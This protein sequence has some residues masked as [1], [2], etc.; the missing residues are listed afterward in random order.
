M[1]Q[2]V[3][4][5]LAA[6]MLG[7]GLMAVTTRNLI[8]SVLWLAIALVSTAGVYALLDASFLASDHR[9]R[10]LLSELTETLAYQVGSFEAGAEYAL[11]AILQSPNF[12][13][14][15]ELGEGDGKADGKWR[16]LPVT[17]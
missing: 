17:R 5:I 4:A 6:L 8:H 3:F 10:P 7:A 13:Y 2:V 9:V 16:V 11:A 15:V 14:R 1:G 12:I